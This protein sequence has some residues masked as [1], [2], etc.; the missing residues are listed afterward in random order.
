VIRHRPAAPFDLP[1]S[2]NCGNKV[3]AD[4]SWQNPQFLG[5]SF[6][7]IGIDALD[8]I[9]VSTAV[10][11]TIGAFPGVASASRWMSADSL[12]ANWI[13]TERYFD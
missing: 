9:L 11:L 8:A 4:I 3:T 12:D 10:T 6:E 13:I 2:S 1:Q 7:S 5:A